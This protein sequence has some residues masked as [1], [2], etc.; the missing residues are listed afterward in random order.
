MITPSSPRPAPLHVGRGIRLRMRLHDLLMDRTV[1]TPYK[2]W[3]DYGLI[4]VVLINVASV[5]WVTEESIPWEHEEILL[6]LDWITT[7]MIT[8]E[9]LLRLWVCVD[10]PP[11]I[12]LA[13]WKA[14][15]KYATTPMGLV[16]LVAIL[17]SYI[18]LLSS[19]D[20][21]VLLILRLLR[22]LKMARYSPGI[23]SVMAAIEAE[24][25]ALVASLLIIV[26]AL[27]L[28]AGIM[29]LI[30]GPVQPQNF[31]S[32]PKAMWWAIITL[33]T[34]G[35]GDVVPV[36]PLGRIFAG[37][38]TLLGIIVCAV[39]AGI[40]ASSFMTEIRKRD[41]VVS[42]RLVAKVPFFHRLD[43]VQLADIA[44][45]LQAQ[46][47]PA[48]HL[49]FH[50]GDLVHRV[51]FL[52]EGEV[53]ISLR[54]GTRLTFG[55]GDFFGERALL[56]DEAH[57]SD[58]MTVSECRVLYLDREPFLAMLRQ[59]VPLRQAIVEMAE[60]R[61]GKRPQVPGFPP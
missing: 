20:A 13:R 39:P 38:T 61:Y 51:Y 57:G 43:A 9:Y 50:H 45:T 28:V 3:L 14:R 40:I 30:E 5:V 44:A 26:L 7:L 34:T 27:V 36:T 48:K 54:D 19:V 37:M 22:L 41:F 29:H 32:I 60:R 58:V 2:T 47:L 10:D 23:S 56:F 59:H 53:L 17:P 42:C 16:D 55:P 49:V 52:I 1:M 11:L 6:A 18:G 4:A 12:R 33:T 15:L 8:L 46:V 24:R 21:R 25:R 35:Y 31:G